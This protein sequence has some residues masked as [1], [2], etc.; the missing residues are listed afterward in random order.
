M[1]SVR[2]IPITNWMAFRVCSPSLRRRLDPNNTAGIPCV[3]P[4]SNSYEYDN[5][6]EL[7][8]ASIYLMVPS[9][10]TEQKSRVGGSGVSSIQFHV[11]RR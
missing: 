3:S 11:N 6:A 9:P 1:H 8:L 7:Q 5:D 4:S 10:T 2:T